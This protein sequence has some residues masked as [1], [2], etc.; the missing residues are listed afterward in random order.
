[1]SPLRWFRKHAT[2]M[3]IIF[4]VVLMAIFGLGPVFDNMAQG[5]Q[6]A[7]NQGE[8]PVIVKYRDGD[9]TRSALDDLQLRHHASRRFLGALVEQAQKQCQKEGVQFSP[10]AQMVPALSRTD[11]QNAVDEQMLNRKFLALRAEDEGVV[12]SEGA[13]EDYLALLATPADFSRR[14][15]KNINKLANQRIPLKTVLDHLQL[16]LKSMQM[17]RYAFVG[18]PLNPIPTEAVELYSRANDRIE[19]EVVPVSVEEYVDKVTEEP[20]NSEMQA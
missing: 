17:Q 19:C 4:G 6:G 7:A 15:W 20:S 9:I 3:L 16:E 10:L 12:M 8:D 18:I 2:W 5:F 14:D 1:M 11:N 13:V